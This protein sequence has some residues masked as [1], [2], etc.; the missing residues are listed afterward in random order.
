MNDWVEGQEAVYLFGSYRSGR[1]PKDF[2]P[3]PV[4]ITATLGS[5]VHCRHKYRS[6]MIRFVPK[7]RLRPPG[8]NGG[9]E[10]KTPQTPP[11]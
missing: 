6:R 10:T 8:Y 5:M 11:N 1:L 7:D 3:V 4:I 2:T 9:D